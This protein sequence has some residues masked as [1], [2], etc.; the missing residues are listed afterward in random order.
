MK[1]DKILKI[2]LIFMYV[3]ISILGFLSYM[4]MAGII[5]E[6]NITIIILTKVA[7]YTGLFVPIIVIASLMIAMAH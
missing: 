5:V 6:T 2:I 7:C 1:K 4:G 3:S